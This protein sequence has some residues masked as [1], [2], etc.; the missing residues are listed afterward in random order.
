[1]MPDPD[2]TPLERELASFTPA[3]IPADVRERIAADLRDEPLTLS[4]RILAGFT[5]LGGIAA[6]VIVL[7]AVW[8]FTRPEPPHPSA[9]E[10]AAHQKALVEYQQLLA[11]R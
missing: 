3:E 9:E 6:G 4:D 1:M 11:A 10:I 5:T 8:Q 7:I 2:P